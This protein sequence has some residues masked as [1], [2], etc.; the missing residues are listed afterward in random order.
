[1]ITPHRRWLSVAGSLLLVLGTAPLAAG[2]GAGNDAFPPVTGGGPPDWVTPG[3][4]LSYY[5]ET[6]SIRTSYYTYVEDSNGEWEVPVTGKRYRRTEEGEM[7]ESASHAFTQSDVIAVDGG[8]VVLDT[9]MYSIDIGTG[10]LSLIPLGGGRFPG[11]AV[12]GAW[13][14]PDLLANVASGGT[15]ELRVLR[16]PYRLGDTTVDAVGFMSKAEGTYAST[17]FDSVSGA[18]VAHTGRAKGPGF[19]VQGPLD[20]PEGNVIIAWARMVDVRQRDLPGMGGSLPDWVEPGLTLRYGGTTTVTNPLDAYGFEMT[21]PVEVTVRFDDVGRDWATF[22]STTTVDYDGYIDT[23]RGGGAT[24]VVGQYWYT[25]DGLAGLEAGSVLDD[26]PITGA[27]L[28]V[29]EVDATAVTLRTTMP[30]VTIVAT[31][32]RD[33]GAMTAMTIGQGY[34]TTDLRLASVG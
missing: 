32:E 20:D 21:S 18:Q 4:R 8:D 6:A 14:R 7:P 25:P 1:M 5:G 11:A 10:L 24:G 19:P 15:A 29:D 2:Q 3:L 16:G 27:R 28:T 13:V 22:S 34:A 26:D 30:G 9:T 31:Y 33:S 12:D 17:V 23:I